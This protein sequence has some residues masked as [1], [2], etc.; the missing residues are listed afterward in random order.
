MEMKLSGMCFQSV[1]SDNFTTICITGKLDLYEYRPH[2][3]RIGGKCIHRLG[4]Q[5]VRGESSVRLGARGNFDVLR[6]KSVGR[7]F[8]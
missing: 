4:S 7:G 3:G 2:T 6:Y 1:Y 5:N 8:E